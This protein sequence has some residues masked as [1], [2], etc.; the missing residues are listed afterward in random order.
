MQ[1]RDPGPDRAGWSQGSVLHVPT[2]GA[3]KL[4]EEGFF[5]GASRFAIGAL[6]APPRLCNV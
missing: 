2:F 6:S 1:H 4:V 5:N 3:A